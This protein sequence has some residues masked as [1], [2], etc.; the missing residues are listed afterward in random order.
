MR[1]I[2][3][4]EVPSSSI[5]LGMPLSAQDLLAIAIAILLVPEALLLMK[6][7]LLVASRAAK[8]PQNNLL[9]P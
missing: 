6:V 5:R 9:T 4:T 8:D 2:K 7:V 1:A 3:Y